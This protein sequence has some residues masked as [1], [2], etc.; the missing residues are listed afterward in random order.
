M[1]NLH[2]SMTS[3]EN[4]SRLLR[5]A[6][7]LLDEGVVG[8]VVVVALWEKSLAETE[9]LQK[10]FKVVR[11]VLKTRGMPKGL[12]FQLVKYVEFMFACFA[13]GRRHKS[14]VV[15]CH[16][17]ASLPIGCF[18]KLVG[19]V[20]LVYDAHELETERN[21]LIGVRKALSKWVERSLIGFCDLVIVPGELIKQWYQERYN[22]YNIISL[23]NIPQFK[24]VGASN[25]LREELTLADDEQVFLYHGNLSPGRGVEVLLECFAHY[26]APSCVLVVMGYGELESLVKEYQAGYPGRIYFK[27]AVSPEEVVDIAASADFGLCLIEP[28]CLSYKYC[29][30]NKMFEYMAAGIPVLA[31]PLPEMVNVLQDWPTEFVERLEPEVVALGVSNIMSKKCRRE[32]FGGF[33][34][35]AE[36]E[37]LKTAYKTYLA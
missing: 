2:I 32:G 6:K 24:P 33:S 35:S 34:W 1:S 27:S 18:F 10:N 36:A 8:E 9:L 17:L 20:K 23:L 4:E 7:T 13:V 21:G 5:E 25:I 30:P 31:S 22:I 37:K 26:A 19:R 14:S 12:L 29:M 3:F 11:I 16:A 28:V 15:N